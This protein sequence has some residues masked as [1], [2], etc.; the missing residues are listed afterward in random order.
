M[1]AKSL[2]TLTSI[3]KVKIN[4]PPFPYRTMLVYYQTGHDFRKHFLLRFFFDISLNYQHC[5]RGKGAEVVIFFTKGMKDIKCSVNCWVFQVLLAG[6]VE[7]DFIIR[8][9][10][11]CRRNDKVLLVGTLPSNE[12]N[13]EYLRDFI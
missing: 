10:R 3:S 9:Y 5:F 2:G 8:G 7:T 1:P 4:H 11:L 13:D 6:I 12:F